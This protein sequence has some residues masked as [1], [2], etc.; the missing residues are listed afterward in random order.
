MEKIV[1]TITTLA[2]AAALLA[3]ASSARAGYTTAELLNDCR[4]DA[5]KTSCTAYVTATWDTF[6]LLADN[7]NPLDAQLAIESICI[8]KIVTIAPSELIKLAEQAVQAQQSLSEMPAATALL[9]GLRSQF[10]CFD[11]RTQ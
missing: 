6:V 2:L 4:A 8:P 11:R 3:G 5:K 9:A 7:K 1:K 10:N